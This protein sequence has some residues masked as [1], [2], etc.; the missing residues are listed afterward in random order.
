MALN[1]LFQFAIS[2]R[3]KFNH[4]KRYE[5]KYIK[6]NIALVFCINKTILNTSIDSEAIINKQ[7][8][9]TI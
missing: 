2:N 9:K 6:V 1:N 3:D 8:D 7:T 4:S 5:E